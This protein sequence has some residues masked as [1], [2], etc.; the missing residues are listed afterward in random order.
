MTPLYNHSVTSRFES[1]YI[2]AV[3][4][5]G[6]NLF[7]QKMEQI[8]WAELGWNSNIFTLL[9]PRHS[10]VKHVYDLSVESLGETICRSFA[11]SRFQFLNFK[12]TGLSLNKISQVTTYVIR[13]TFMSSLFLQAYTFNN[14]RQ[15]INGYLDF[16][17]GMNILLCF[18]LRYYLDW[19]H[20]K[21]PYTHLWN[22]IL[23]PCR[24]CCRRLWMRYVL[25]SK[26]WEHLGCYFI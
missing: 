2:V 10:Y 5:R 22:M 16:M 8:K 26:T 14:K 23:R 25:A 18:L 24:T 9:C 19:E 17:K 20:I 7:G 1:I 4:H 3:Q 11:A 15:N 13:A 21:F 12:V 6:F